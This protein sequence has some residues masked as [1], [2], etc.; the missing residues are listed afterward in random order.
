MNLRAIIID[1][2]LHSLHTTEILVQKNC[3]KIEIIG[4]AESPEKG[5]E[6]IDSLQPDLVF[7]D[8]AMPVMNGFEMLQHVSYRNFEIIFTTA[9]DEY[10]IKAFKVN[11]IDYLLKPI[12][13]PELLEAV[14]KVKTKFDK[15]EEY[16]KVEELLKI[17]GKPGI[18]REKVALPIDGKIQMTSFSSIIYCE[19]ESNYTYIYFVNDKK[20]LLSKTL[21][22][23]E[24]LLDHSDF[25]RVQ[26]SYLVNLN[27]I[28][29]YIR[30]EGGEL[31]M[32]NGDEVRVSRNKKE[33][34]LALLT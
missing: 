15:N 21:K 4:L 25:F 1:D 28:K 33:Q 3:S 27:H 19:S 9:Y 34:L 30:G 32:S 22:E 10:A 20:A 14:T 29:E 12:D 24:K 11:A 13:V 5:I 23:I 8:I 31:V 17:F 6:L 26:N 16:N 18:K 2:E 7:L